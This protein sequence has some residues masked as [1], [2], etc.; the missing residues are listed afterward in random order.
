MSFRIKPFLICLL[1][2]GCNDVSL[3]E[4]LEEDE[5]A[6]L[7]SICYPIF[8]MRNSGQFLE[9][10]NG[11][12]TETSET[13]EWQFIPKKLQGE[14]YYYI[15]HAE[16]RKYV[17]EF[18]NG[19]VVLSS[20]ASNFG[21]WRVAVGT[22]PVSV[23]TFYNGLHFINAKSGKYLTIQDD[24]VRT[25]IFSP[26]STSLQWVI[27]SSIGSAR[28]FTRQDY[29]P[30]EI[31]MAGLERTLWE[32]SEYNQVCENSP[33]AISFLLAACVYRFKAKSESKSWEGEVTITD[34]GCTMY[35]LQ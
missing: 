4:G 18:P 32:Y 15:R 17:T 12:D 1:L 10:K 28:F 20:N 25:E 2:L 16:T 27:N 5:L 26:T 14:D 34:N 33:H 31:E 19:M 30:I 21:L 24:M 8:S 11:F 13:R 29:G 22:T 9:F 23:N 35:E 3:V 6:E 7:S